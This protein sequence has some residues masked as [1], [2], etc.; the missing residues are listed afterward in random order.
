MPKLNPGQRLLWLDTSFVLDG[1]G[2]PV[3]AL[4]YPPQE[5]YL[6]FGDCNQA[7]FSW[8]TW[9]SGPGRNDVKM[10]F[11]RNTLDDQPNMFVNMNATIIA[12][13]KTGWNSRDFGRAANVS[14]DLLPEGQGRVL[15]SNAPAGADDFA[16]VRIRMWVAGQS[17]A[18]AKGTSS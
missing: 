4:W 8:Q 11:Q 10:F 18:S 2:G 5:D 7:Y 1:T 17:F 12:L 3:S 13:S 6:D 15:I 14:A 16:A 9:I